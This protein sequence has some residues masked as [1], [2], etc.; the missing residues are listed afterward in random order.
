MR[1]R[2]RG[3]R[4]CCA[5]LASVSAQGLINATPLEAGGLFKRPGWPEHCGRQW[6]L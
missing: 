2:P 3:L 1:M 6:L 5:A 4:T